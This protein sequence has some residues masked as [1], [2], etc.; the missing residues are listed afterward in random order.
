M[1][2]GRRRFMV[3]GAPLMAAPVLG[4]APARAAPQPADAV[5]DVAYWVT[6]ASAGGRWHAVVVDLISGTPTVVLD[7]DPDPV[8]DGASVQKVAIAAAVLEKVDRG[9]LAL[10]DTV[11]LKSQFIAPGSGIYCNQ[12]AYGDSLT[13]AG[14]LT[15]M[16]QVSDNSA[17]RMLGS[18]VPG[19]EINAILAAKGLTNTRVQPLPDNPHRFWMGVT[20]ARE[21]ADLLTRLCMGQLLSAESTALMLNVMTWSEVGYTDGIRRQMSSAERARVATKFGADDDKRH[22]VGVLFDTA[23]APAVVFAFLAEGAGD[24]DNFGATNPIAQAHAALGRALMD[25]FPGLSAVPKPVARQ[26]FNEYQRYQP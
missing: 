1:E 12:G 4:D 11:S 5:F 8:L 16:L 7:D 21:M 10:T 23:G 18:L 9:E 25:S 22:E 14:L 24:P 13:V 2:I 17:V 3:S 20:T 19:T 6:K 26:H 15:A